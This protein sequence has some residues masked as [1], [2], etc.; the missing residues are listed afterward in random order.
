MTKPN[1]LILEVN[2][3]LCAHWIFASS[4]VEEAKLAQQLSALGVK[5]GISMNEFQH[6]F[7]MILRIMK[8]KSD[9][10]K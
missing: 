4:E 1:D 5:T 8:S 2:E 10:S 3:A 9:W 7:P 6:I